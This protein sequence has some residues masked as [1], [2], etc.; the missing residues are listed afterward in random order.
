MVGLVP[1]R[2]PPPKNISACRQ[3]SGLAGRRC[4]GT[5]CPLEVLPGRPAACMRAC[6]TASPTGGAVGQSNAV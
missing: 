4:Y 1:R 2:D 3:K 6:P 5:F